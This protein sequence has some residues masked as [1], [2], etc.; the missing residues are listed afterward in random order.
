MHIN[1]K[2]LKRRIDKA[3]GFNVIKGSQP[4]EWDVIIEPTIEPEYL[5]VKDYRKR[6]ELLG[7]TISTETPA[8]GGTVYRIAGKLLDDLEEKR[9]EFTSTKDLRATVN[10]LW[11]ISIE[12]EIEGWIDENGRAHEQ[13]VYPETPLY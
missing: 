5:K 10:S 6:A 4:E 11:D 13:L 1:A 3:Q 9:R 12:P 2:R 7:L 8:D